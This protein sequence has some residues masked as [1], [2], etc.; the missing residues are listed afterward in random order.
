MIEALPKNY[1]LTNLAIMQCTGITNQS[2]E[3]L[4]D[5]V[6]DQNMTLHKIDLD[7]SDRRFDMKL[8]LDVKDEAHLNKSI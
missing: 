2:L 7:E 4:Y 6:R 8:A 1:T 3:A 5:L